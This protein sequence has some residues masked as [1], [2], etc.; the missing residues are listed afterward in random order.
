MFVWSVIHN[1]IALSTNGQ[2][3][4][5]PQVHDYGRRKQLQQVARQ[6]YVRLMLAEISFL[7]DDAANFIFLFVSILFEKPK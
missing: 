7:E 5:G 2:V 3:H 4:P 6:C 1:V